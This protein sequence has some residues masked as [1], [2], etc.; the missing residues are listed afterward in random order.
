MAIS[1]SDVIR[2]NTIG[3]SDG[4]PVGVPSSWD[5]YN[6]TN[7]PAGGYS[8]PPSGFTAVNGWAQVYQEA[9]APAYT[10]PNA[11]VEV[12]NAKT[13]VHL[14]TTGEWVLVQEQAKTGI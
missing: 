8:A 5:W 1:I 11:K 4:V 12:A 6:G 3:N 2:Q 13:Y 10:N 9:G 14:K 7:K